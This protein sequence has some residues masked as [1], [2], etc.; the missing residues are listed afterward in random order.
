MAA[1]VKQID[2]QSAAGGTGAVQSFR[3]NNVELLPAPVYPSEAYAVANYP[4]CDDMFNIFPPYGNGIIGTDGRK[5]IVHVITG[6]VLPVAIEYAW[7]GPHEVLPVCSMGGVSFSGYAEVNVYIE[8]Q[9]NSGACR[10]VPQITA[11]C[12]HS[13]CCRMS[14]VGPPVADVVSRQRRVRV[15]RER[16]DAADLHLCVRNRPHRLFRTDKLR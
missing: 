11:S 15:R 13:S 6:D 8:A 7:T 16:P 2:W 10:D 14:G 4:H 1:A 9:D 5:S 3:V 12:A